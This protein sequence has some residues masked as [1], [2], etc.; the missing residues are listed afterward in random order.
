M[1]WPRRERH[2]WAHA[3]LFSLCR[4]RCPSHSP[5]PVCSI[6]RSPV[7]LHC[8]SRLFSRG[9]TNAPIA[10]S[11]PKHNDAEGNVASR[12]RG[13]T[14]M[15]PR[16]E[17]GEEEPRAAQ[18]SAHVSPA[19]R[20]YR[21][22]LESIFAMLT[23]EDLAHILAVSRS[24]SAA[25]GSM[26]LIQASMERDARKSRI[27]GKVFRPLP[28]IARIVG[29]PLLRHLVTI[30]IEDAS[31]HWTPL[32]CASLGLLAQHAPNLTSLQCKLRSCQTSR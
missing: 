11:H 25:V 6:L 16:D 20:V 23:L 14:R 17:D 7:P 3:A 18:S 29:S 12:A 31:R 9:S 1:G 32:N 5:R 24:W 19:M 21:H 22:A 10:M 30:Q 8:A 4:P 15:R 26:K 13:Q 28:P 2:T 27:G